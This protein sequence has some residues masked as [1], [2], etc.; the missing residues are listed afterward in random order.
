MTQA[1]VKAK[2]GL[3]GKVERGSNEIGPYT[4]YRYRTYRVTFFAGGNVTQLDTLSTRERT[5]TGVGVGSTR[6]EVAARV[7]GVRCLEE[8]G[9]NHCYVGT[10]KP[11]RVITDFAIKNGRVSRI[12]IGYVID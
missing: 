5:T 2:V 12:S 4:T 3:P 7:A 8:F 6:A 11:G 10:W 9:Y 1:Q